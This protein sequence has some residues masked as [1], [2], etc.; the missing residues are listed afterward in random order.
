MKA[1]S[2]KNSVLI[3]IFIFGILFPIGD[4]VSVL[5]SIIVICAS[6]I[7]GMCYPYLAQLDFGLYNYIIEEP[8]WSQ[9]IDYRKPLSFAQFLGYFLIFCGGGILVGE[10][11]QTFSVNVVAISL[12]SIGL[13][14]IINIPVAV[15][16]KKFW[17]RQR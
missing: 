10:L 13:G 17:S 15:K 2:I 5:G 4:S 14:V 6:F 3:L 8:E 9:P 1:K 12:L 7:V 11:I 16:N